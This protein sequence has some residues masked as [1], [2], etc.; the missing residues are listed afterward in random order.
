MKMF[1]ALINLFVRLSVRL[2]ACPLSNR[3]A[4]QIHPIS[5]YFE[6]F[7]GLQDS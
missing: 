1:R 2:S 6:K 3:A 7:L 4:N 5:I